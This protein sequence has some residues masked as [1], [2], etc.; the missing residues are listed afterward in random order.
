MNLRYFVWGMIHGPLPLGFFLVRIHDQL[1]CCLCCCCCCCWR[2]TLFYVCG[3]WRGVAFRNLNG[4]KLKILI[5]P[6][7][8]ALSNWSPSALVTIVD[9]YLKLLFVV[10]VCLFIVFGLFLF[11]QFR[12]LTLWLLLIYCVTMCP[13]VLEFFFVGFNFHFD[14]DSED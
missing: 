4:V 9:S 10:V 13:Q 2:Y 7:P 5:A 6:V 1:T 12:L 11:I 8:S 3:V 14:S